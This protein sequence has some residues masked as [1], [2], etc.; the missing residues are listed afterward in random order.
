MRNVTS[1]V[2]RITRLHCANRGCDAAYDYSGPKSPNGAAVEAIEHGWGQ[3]VTGQL[4]CPEHT[5]GPVV[6]SVEWEPR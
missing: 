6:S 5:G 1:R 4:Q 3:H 2:T